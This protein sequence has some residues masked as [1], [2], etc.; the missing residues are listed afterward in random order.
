MIS[1]KSGFTLLEVLA[2]L[3]IVL[4]CV[5]GIL[6]LLLLSSIQVNLLAEKTTS[7]LTASSKLAELRAGGTANLEQWK[8]ENSFHQA[9]G[10]EAENCLCSGWYSTVSVLNAGEE[11]FYRV[12]MVVVGRTGREE[13]FITYLSDLGWSKAGKVA[14]PLEQPIK[15]FQ[16]E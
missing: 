4:L 2:S 8:K 5:I 7:Y 3:V 10:Q 13:T 1:K 16:S 12:V 6:Q 9:T 11:K 15:L 14:L